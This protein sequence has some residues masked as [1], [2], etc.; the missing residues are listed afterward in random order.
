MRQRVVVL[1]GVAL[2]LA[3]GCGPV[4]GQAMKA[5]TGFKDFQVRAGSARDFAA[6]KN[7]LV[8]APFAK[9]GTG[10]FICRGEDEWAIAE[11]L[12]AAGLYAVQYSFERDSDKAAAL[13]AVL[14]AA[15]PAE[16][17][18]KLGLESAPDA[19][20]SGAV[21]GREETVA[22]TVGIIETLTL[23]LDLTNLISKKTASLE[24]TVKAV[25]KDSIPLIVE[26]LLRRAGAPS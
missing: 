1:G 7:V 14:R 20:L 19:I 26:E 2:L 8:F 5:S 9:G 18:A 4:I 17:Q 15:T 12:R 16:V 6:P 22:P 23:R 11:R 21:L 3:A 13:L 25:R 10:Y 24:V